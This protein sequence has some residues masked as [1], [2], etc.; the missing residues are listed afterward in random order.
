MALVN[1]LT[2]WISDVRNPEIRPRIKANRAIV[3]LGR[4]HYIL[5]TTMNLTPSEKQQ[6]QE[7]R[8]NNTASG[9]AQVIF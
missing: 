3:C 2:I 4:A 1:G 6:V 5:L 9:V 8:R 7:G